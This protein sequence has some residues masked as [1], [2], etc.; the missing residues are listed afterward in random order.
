MLHLL[1]SILHYS[2]CNMKLHSPPHSLSTFEL[3]PFVSSHW[4]LSVFHV[5]THQLHGLWWKLLISHK[6]VYISDYRAWTATA[7]GEE[8][9]VSE[10][11]VRLGSIVLITILLS[12][13]CIPMS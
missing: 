11:S 9:P 5:C 12:I 13:S 1:T 8:K 2:V 6:V 4:L 3:C 7:K 10:M